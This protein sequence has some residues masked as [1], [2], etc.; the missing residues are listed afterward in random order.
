LK[1][2]Q[3]RIGIGAVAVVHEFILTNPAPESA[4]KCLGSHHE[5]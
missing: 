1:R 4:S 5:A 3:Q 2:T